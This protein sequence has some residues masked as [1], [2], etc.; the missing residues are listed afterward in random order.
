MVKVNHF[1]SVYCVLRPKFQRDQNN[2][3]RYQSFFSVFFNGSCFIEAIR[4]DKKLK[5]RLRFPLLNV[6]ND[7]ERYCSQNKNEEK[8]ISKRPILNLNKTF[9]YSHIFI[10]SNK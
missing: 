8:H 4:S 6:N 2:I 10:S 9:D 1:V 5:K 3:L 7:F